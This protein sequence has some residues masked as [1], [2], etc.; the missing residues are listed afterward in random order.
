MHA[1][2]LIGQESSR[3][4]GQNIIPLRRIDP[5]RLVFTQRSKFSLQLYQWGMLQLQLSR[6]RC[7]IHSVV[8]HGRNQL[9]PQSRIWQ[10]A[11]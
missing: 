10:L 7:D 9:R 5:M 1:A 6:H 8:P 4:Q 2:V 11:K 3:R